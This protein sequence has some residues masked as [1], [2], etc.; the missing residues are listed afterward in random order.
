MEHQPVDYERVNS[1]ISRGFFLKCTNDYLI[2]LYECVL[3]IKFMEFLYKNAVLSKDIKN[4]VA[5]YQKGVLSCCSRQV[6]EKEV[7]QLLV[8]IPENRQVVIIG[9][10]YIQ[11]ERKVKYQHKPPY[12]E[13]VYI[14]EKIV[15]KK[16]SAKVKCA[17]IVENVET[18]S[19]WELYTLVMKF[20]PDDSVYFLF[21]LESKPARRGIY[22]GNVLSQILPTKKAYPTKT[23]FKQS[24]IVKDMMVLTETDTRYWP[25]TTGK[26]N[27]KRIK[28]SSATTQVESAIIDVYEQYV[29]KQG[30][31]PEEI[32]IV[33]TDSTYLNLN[34]QLAQIDM[35]SKENT[36]KHYC[37]TLGSD[38]Y[39]SGSVLRY[40]GITDMEKPRYRIKGLH[41][42]GIELETLETK[43]ICKRHELSLTVLADPSRVIIDNVPMKKSSKTDALILTTMYDS[44]LDE[45][46]CMIWPVK[47]SPHTMEITG[48]NTKHLTY[49]YAIPFDE[50]GSREY[51]CVIC[52]VNGK[53]S[54][55]ILTRDMVY[56]I[57][58][59]ATEQVCL[60]GDVP[61]P[62]GRTLK[63]PKGD[64]TDT[65]L[66]KARTRISQKNGRTLCKL[67]VE[68]GL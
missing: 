16:K 66:D 20:R 53:E 46:V 48:E 52:Y 17:Y 24:D 29:K 39:Y 61:E 31:K 5:K 45:Q 25:L 22:L 47:K 10:N 8:D 3:E 55:L 4:T 37:Y 14:P 15:P 51:K 30:Y 26:K 13:P 11:T 1:A 35:E 33:T 21:D 6:L 62:R 65:A 56:T 49:G 19:L 12:T 41:A 43:G 18:Y 40:T 27:S 32:L 2:P 67:L 34:P 50:I 59:K 54:D 58:S 7:K 44:L 68:G 28:L 63:T 9:D 60:I 23:D 42:K 57:L 36:R 64:E 38:K